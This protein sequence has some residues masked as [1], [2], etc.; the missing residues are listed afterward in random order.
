MNEDAQAAFGAPAS[1][2]SASRP[3]SAGFWLGGLLIALAVAGAIA[4][5]VLGFVS[6]SG[7]VDDLQRV[8]I[9]DGGGEVTLS[10]GKKAIYYEA[11]DAQERTPPMQ[12]AIEGVRVGP[13]S[14]SVSYSISGHTGQS[15]A[16][17][18]IPRDGRYRLTV[19]DDGA[20]TAGAELA[21]GEGI[22][23]RIV[24][25]IVGGFAIFFVGAI[26]G[27]V[28]IVVTATRRRRTT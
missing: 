11:S 25:I 21:I 16:S 12:I 26:A 6:F 24:R 10:A 18:R 13:H 8:S 7:A 20:A 17:A 5:V 14:G 28:L 4:W 23:S 9:A 1:P 27:T 15:V 2:S 22:G 3:S 19:S